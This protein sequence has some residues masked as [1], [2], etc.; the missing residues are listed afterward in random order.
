LQIAA[1]HKA[2]SSA[3]IHQHIELEGTPTAKFSY[4]YWDA[5]SAHKSEFILV[6]LAQVFNFL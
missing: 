4:L 6:E 3:S 1:W 2:K 5:E